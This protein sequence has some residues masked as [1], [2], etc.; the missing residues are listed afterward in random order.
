MQR[1]LI[2]FEEAGVASPTEF[3]V[4]VDVQLELVFDEDPDQAVA[5]DER[6]V[7]QL[8]AVTSPSPRPHRSVARSLVPIADQSIAG[9]G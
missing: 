1:L 3:E 5:P 9:A 2:S 6:D 8:I 7:P 4:S